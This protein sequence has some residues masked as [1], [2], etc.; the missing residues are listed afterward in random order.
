MVAEANAVPQEIGND[1]ERS[2]ASDLHDAAY[3]QKQELYYRRCC[4]VLSIKLAYIAIRHCAPKVTCRRILD[5]RHYCSFCAKQPQL[6]GEPHLHWN[7]A[8]SEAQ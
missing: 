4:H 2:F 6:R 7:L 3:R 8:K 1:C 5:M